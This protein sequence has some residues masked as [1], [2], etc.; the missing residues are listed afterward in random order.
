MSP[1]SS[2]LCNMSTRLNWTTFHTIT[3]LQVTVG[4]RRD[5]Y[6]RFGRWKES[7]CSFVACTCRH[8]YADSPC[9]HRAVARPA[10]APPSSGSYFSFPDFWT[11]CVFNSMTKGHMSNFCR[12]LTSSRADAMRTDADFGP[13]SWGPAHAFGSR[14]CS[15]T[16]HPF[17]LPHCLPCAD[18]SF[19]SHFAP[20][21]LRRFSKSLISKD[22]SSSNIQDVNIHGFLWEFN[23]W[24]NKGIEL[25]TKALSWRSGFQPQLCLSIAMGTWSRSFPSLGCTCPNMFT[26]RS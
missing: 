24:N 19:T 1:H 3:F 23:L 11:M 13:H 6:R 18:M 16:L 26:C 21:G 4:H 7:S 20:V 9:S 8:L 12:T 22:T 25:G 14:P 17:S 5:S 2:C 15:P 10:T